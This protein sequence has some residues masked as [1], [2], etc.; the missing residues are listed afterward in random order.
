MG[1][2]ATASK[3]FA[4]QICLFAGRIPL[5]TMKESTTYLAGPMLGLTQPMQGTI[6]GGP[7][8]Q[9]LATGATIPSPLGA[10]N[11]QMSVSG[12]TTFTVIS[13]QFS[14]FTRPPFV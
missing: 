4:I 12:G 11:V 7:G 2:I 6:V 1:T 5:M 14:R 9:T 3:S 8:S 13:Y 10:A